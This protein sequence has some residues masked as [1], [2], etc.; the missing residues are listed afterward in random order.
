MAYLH[1]MNRYDEEE[2][3]RGLADILRMLQI[4]NPAELQAA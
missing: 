1:R 3:A 4:K 2:T